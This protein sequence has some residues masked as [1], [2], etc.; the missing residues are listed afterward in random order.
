MKLYFTSLLSILLTLSA[1]SAQ[2][3][4]DPTLMTINGK[5]V[6]LSEFEYIYN[7]NNSNNTVDKKSLDEYVDLFV[8]FKLKVEEAIA[9]GLDTTQS[10]KNEFEMYRN[11]LAEQYLT[12][13]AGK[14]KLTREAY[15]RKQNEVEV[16]HILVRI[17]QSGTAKDTLESFNKIKT[18]YERAQKEDFEKLAREVSEDPSVAQNGGYVGWI[19]A[20]RTP[21]TFEKMAYSTPVGKVSKPVRTFLGYHLIKVMNKRQSPGEV[22]VAHILLT[23]NRE[24]PTQ[25]PAIGQR[26]DSI[27]N[28]IKAGQ[29]FGELATKFSQDPGSAS[30][31]GELPWFGSG[32]MIPEF[33]AASFALKDKGD[34]TKPIR[35]Q[36]GWHIIQLIDKKTMGTYDEMKS[37]LENEIKQNERGQQSNDSF[38]DDLKS[39]YNY[40]VSDNAL[41]DYYNLTEKYAPND[42]LF[43]VEINKLNAP[44]A[45]FADVNITQEEFNNYLANRSYRGGVRSDYIKESFNQ[46]ISDRLRAYEKTQLSG[47]YPDYRNLE[48]EYHD[49]ILLFE[50]MNREVWDKASKDT[51][52][53]SEYFNANKSKYTW[54]KPH[55]KGRIVYAKDKETLKAAKLIVKKAEKDSVD[56]YLQQRLNDSIQYVKTEKGLWAEGENPVIDGKIFKK[57]KYTPTEEYPFYFIS[58]KKLGTKPENYTDVRG[59]VTADYQDYLE[60][61]WISHLRREYPVSIDEKVLKTVKKN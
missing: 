7:K 52:G 3:Q 40:R 47:K 35:S 59:T 46:Y 58:G 42:S 23:E 34:F 25:N 36:Y 16:A 6:H 9:Q 10:F 38:I 20:M 26:A 50:I 32:R 44:I 30:K 15:E 27:Y 29:D 55:Y 22:K 48:N 39:Q 28:L 13:D 21:Y 43:T 51:D 11:Q 12:D 8:N 31:K 33:E 24:D 56:K 61:T 5:D 1:L 57:S 54:D 53:L 45:S 37:Q 14:E 18:Y 60:K 2:Q 19:S 4:S 49:G 17:P 41:A